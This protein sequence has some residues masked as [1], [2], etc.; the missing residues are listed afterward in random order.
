MGTIDGNIC[1][2]TRCFY[3][4]Q[5]HGWRKAINFCMKKDGET[6]WVSTASKKCLA[7]SSTDTA[8]ALI[9]LGA[10][11]LL[12]SSD[13]ER[14]VLL[15][16]LYQDDGINYMKRR[17]DE[18]LIK[19]ILPEADGWKSSYWKSRRRGSF[20]FPVLSVASALRIESDGTIADARIV[21]GA[22]SSEPVTCDDVASCLID[23]KLTDDVIE[24]AA[25]LSSKAGR[26]VR[27]T[28]Y[29]PPWRRKTVSKITSRALRELSG[30]DMREAQGSKLPIIN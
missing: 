15:S 16:D 29:S 8:P 11:V 17:Q 26:P 18:I 2:D 14:T 5:S 27:N 21:L 24:E 22:V 23:N 4:D 20:D 28:D 9:S 3:Y 1:L 6:C 10:K 13:G 25:K 12:V 19:V 30:D 7:T